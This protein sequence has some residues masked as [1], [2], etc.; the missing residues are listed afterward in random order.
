MNKLNVN[1]S[2]NVITL[3]FKKDLSAYPRKIEYQGNIYDF[4]DAGLKCIVRHG[5]RIAEIITMSDGVSSYR[6]RTDNRGGA[7]TLLSITA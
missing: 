5:G 3:G 1:E 4:I 6:M 2:V 7:W